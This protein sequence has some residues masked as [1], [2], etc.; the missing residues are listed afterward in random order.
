MPLIASP[1]S[2]PIESAWEDLESCPNQGGS[3]VQPRL[4]AGE[5]LPGAKFCTFVQTLVRPPS[6]EG[7]LPTGGGQSPRINPK[8]SE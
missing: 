4:S 3:L 6:M 2:T 7:I 8:E 5:M 1:S